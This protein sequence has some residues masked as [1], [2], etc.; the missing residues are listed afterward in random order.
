MKP[1]GDLRHLLAADF[2][3]V[4]GEG[5]AL[6]GRARDGGRGGRDLDPRDVARRGKGERRGATCTDVDEFV[7]E[8]VEGV[9]GHRRYAAAEAL[10]AVVIVVSR[11]G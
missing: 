9:D 11:P 8:G 3:P 2:A 6:L 1:E 4:D 5:D 10:G 7:P